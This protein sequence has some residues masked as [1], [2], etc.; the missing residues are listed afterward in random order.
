MNFKLH[1]TL[2]LCFSSASNSRNS[3]TGSNHTYLS[4]DALEAKLYAIYEKVVVRVRTDL[5]AE[6]KK[7]AAAGKPKPGG[8]ARKLDLGS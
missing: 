4:R 1:Y 8:K 3:V 6:E 2:A 7:E 5:D